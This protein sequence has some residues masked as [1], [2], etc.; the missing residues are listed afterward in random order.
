M[1]DDAYV[2]TLAWLYRLD[3]VHGIDLKLERVRRAAAALGHPERCAP[4]FHVAGTNG[5]GSTAAMLAAMLA[6]DGRRVGLYTSPHLVSFRERITIGGVPIAEDAV[7][8]GVAAI[9]RRLGTGLDL[10]CFEVMTLLAWRTFAAAQVEVVVLEVG[11][12]GRLDATNVV[13]PVVA[14]VTN[15]GL[16]HEA[17]LGPDV[18]TIAGE[19]A[20]IIKAA[21]P[22]VSGATGVAGEVVAARARELGS[23]IEV[24]DRDFTLGP[25]LDGTLAYRSPRGSLGPIVLA[26]AGMH[27]RRNA[28]LAIRALELAPMLTPSRAAMLAG[29]ADVRWPGRLQVVSREPLVL[30][31]GAHNAAGIAA[32]IAEIRSRAAGRRVRVLFGVMRDKGWQS[33]LAAL[34][35]V[36]TEIVVTRPRQPRSAEPAD[37]AAGRSG[38]VRTCGDPLTAYRQLVATSGPDDVVVVAGSLFLVGDLL[39]VVDPTLAAAAE[40]ERAAARLA[41]RC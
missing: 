25:E 1:A 18:A 39:P 33:M 4:T 28:A 21:V 16:D 27:Q 8:E 38:R 22:V 9:R 40:R 23:P 14:V 6:A 2:A 3:A 32:L 36:A 12:G 15:V 41:G 20:G 30:L 7:V 34:G 29:L 37:L 13:T 31:D 26:L 19:K 24:L 17:Y 35:E 11:L 10:T 5:K